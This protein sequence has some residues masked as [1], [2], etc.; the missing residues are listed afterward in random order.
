MYQLTTIYIVCAMLSLSILY[1]LI[2][3]CNLEMQVH[4]LSGESGPIAS[5]SSE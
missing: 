2:R 4:T 3:V 5:D 1:V